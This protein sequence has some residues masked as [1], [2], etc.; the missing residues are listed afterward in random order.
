MP[1]PTPNFSAVC[2]WEAQFLAH[3]A[4]DAETGTISGAGGAPSGAVYIT[5][6]AA[7]NAANP[8]VQTYQR[9]QILVSTSAADI[10]LHCILYAASVTGIGAVNRWVRMLELNNF[11][12]TLRAS[13]A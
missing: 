5:H 2:G 7:T 13:L 11:G 10:S 3:E 8:P 6:T 1:L 4:A 9:S 12:F